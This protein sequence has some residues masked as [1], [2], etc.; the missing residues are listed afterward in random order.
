[1]LILVYGPSGIGKSTALNAVA[2]SCTS[3][4][5]HVLDD[6]TAAVGI[7]RGIILPAQK[8][9]HLMGQ[10]GPDAFLECGIEAIAK[11]TGSPHVIDVGAGFLEAKNSRDWLQSADER[12]CFMAS[13]EECYRRIRADALRPR[14]T[15]SLE[16]Y[17]EVEFP[18][19]RR[20][21]YSAATHT[22]DVGELSPTQVAERL[23][24]LLRLMI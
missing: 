13:P 21:L 12:I 6:I 3:C 2:R 16:R 15:R 4:G 7:N 18:P 17:R 24:S 1:M 9:R 23:L 22:L 11:L 19:R 20:D 5:Y 14:E 8:A 10:I